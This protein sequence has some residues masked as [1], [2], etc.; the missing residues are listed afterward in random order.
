MKM[1][2]RETASKSIGK[3]GV[4]GFLGLLG[5]ALLGGGFYSETV[6]SKDLGLKPGEFVI[7]VDAPLP[8]PQSGLELPRN[9]RTTDGPYLKSQR[10]PTRT[11]LKELKLSGSA[12][13]SRIQ[14]TN[15]LKNLKGARRKVLVMDLRQESHALLG[16]LAISWYG[17]DNT[18]NAGKTLEEIEADEASRLA[19]LR[20]MKQVSV[21]KWE[22]SRHKD[23]R[24]KAEFRDVIV[25]VEALATEKEWVEENGA[26]YF[27]LP[28]AD[29]QRP[30][31]LEV[32]RFLKKYAELKTGN[33]WVHMHCAAGVGRTTTFMILFDMLQNCQKL[34]E[35]EII[36]R[37]HLL[38]GADL[39]VPSGKQPIRKEWAVVR[40]AFIHDFYRYCKAQGPDFKTSWSN[41]LNSRGT[42]PNTRPNTEPHV[43]SSPL[44]SG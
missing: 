28:V 41:W 44:T 39:L 21:K 29:H 34:S 33:Y 31:N 4:V 30:T 10:A 19:Q 2:L 16:D 23:G 42:E 36:S 11:G 20:S 22:H 7:T 17:K 24:K 35:Q 27:R 40:R 12:A 25:P 15:L 18:L 32:D 14:F 43:K 26:E 38:G 3:L 6:Y 8:N 13:F 9:W 37:Q 1:N 5:T